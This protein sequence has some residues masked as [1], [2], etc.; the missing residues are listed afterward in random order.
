M[1]A[2]PRLLAPLMALMLAL[3][4]GCMLVPGRFVS[5]LDLRR[6][7]TFTF[8]YRGEIHLLAMS[9]LMNQGRA[10]PAD[11]TPSTCRADETGGERECSR[12]EIDA[13]R[14]EWQDE[15]NRAEAT[16]RKENE[17]MKAMLGGLDPGDPRAAEELAQRLRRQV[18]WKRV[19][20]KGDGLFDVDFALT[21]ALGHDF[22]FPTIERFPLDNAFVQVALRSDGSVRVDAPGFGPGTG[23]EPWRN[24]MQMAALAGDDKTAP[25]VPVI[26][27]TFIVRTDG[28][29][30]SNNT[31]EGPQAGTTGQQLAWTINARTAAVPMAVIRLR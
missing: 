22:R 4:A 11:F 9:R 7:G 29:V 10:A 16:R 13:Q 28:A 30:L 8:T 21:G 24:M 31:D 18:G 20:Y 23:G 12:A 2:A 25:R 5:E 17:Q 15:R 6:D 1:I 19:D 14:R 27:G 26:D 3:L